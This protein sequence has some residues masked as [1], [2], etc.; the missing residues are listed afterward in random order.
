M[1]LSIAPFVVRRS[2]AVTGLRRFANNIQI[3]ALP[4]SLA[5]ISSA[6]PVV[7]ISVCN[8]KTTFPTVLLE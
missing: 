2:S 5:D 1:P 3:S 4:P 7:E 6:R 8:A